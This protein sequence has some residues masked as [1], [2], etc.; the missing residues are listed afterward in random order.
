M[1]HPRRSSRP[2]YHQIA[3]DLRV[4]ITS[5]DLAPDAQLPTEGELCD[6]YVV[7][8][9]TVRQA[10]G[11]LLNEGLIVSVRPR[12]YFVRDRKHMTYRPQDEYCPRP[13]NPSADQFLTSVAQ[14]GRSASQ[15][16][17]VAIIIP[18]REIAERLQLP[19]GGRAVV[20][21]RVRAIDGEPFNINDSYFPSDLVERSE[22]TNPADI[23]RG[24]NKVLAELG[25][26]QIRATD[27]IYVRMPRPIEVTRLQL[28]PGTPVAVHYLTGYTAQDRPVR[29]VENV[30]P[31]DRHVIVYE[32]RKSDAQPGTEA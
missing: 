13:E 24:A 27:E 21:R 22:I 26:E 30:L 28:G 5:G 14:E 4:Q 12:G 25:H 32:R 7:N 10:L 23:A 15:A 11:L 8:R 6:R 3:D 9:G 18:P 19:E 16:I 2:I 20:R 17:E 29:V 31:G 1:T